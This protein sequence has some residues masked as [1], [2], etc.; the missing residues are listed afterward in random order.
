MTVTTLT[1][2]IAGSTY[3]ILNDGSFKL[4]SKIDETSELDLTIRDE[5]SAWIFSKG[6]QVTLTDTLQGTIFTGFVN[7]SI[8]TKLPGTSSVRFHQLTC[9]DNHFL[10]LKRT[11]NKTY[12]NQ[13]AGVVVA[14]MVND[15]LAA[16]GVTANYAIREDS[17]EE[18]FSQGTLS[19]LVATSNNGGDLELAPAG[20]DVTI[21][22]NTSALFS[23]GTLQGTTASNNALSPTATPTI[24]MQCTQ[25]LAG[26]P[27]S[28]CYARIWSPGSTFPVSSPG[29]FI[30]YDIFI[31]PSSPEC[32]FGVDITF[33]DGT[34]LRDNFVYS[35]A[36]NLSPHPNTDLSSY[37][38]G[39][40]YHREFYLANFVGKDIYYITIAC[41]GDKTGTYTAY[42]KN[43]NYENND[44]SF[45]QAFFSSSL[46]VNPPQVMLTS[47]Y[48]YPSISVV[49]TCDCWSSTPARF[50]PFYSV[51]AVKILQGSFITWDT[52]LP[53]GYSMTVYCSIDGNNSLFPCNNNTALPNV[54]PGI[55][56]SGR[57]VSF[58]VRFYATTSANPEQFPSLTNFECVL[59][60]SY[61][62][63]KID[64]SYTTTGSWSTGATLTNTVA[65]S[66]VLNLIGSVRNWDDAN[67]SGQSTF[68][69]SSPNGF[70]QTGNFLLSTG[71][72]ST[73]ARSEFT[74]AGSYQNFTAEI[75][76][77]IESGFQVGFV[78][79]TTFWG[80]TADTY[81]YMIGVTNTAI[82]FGHGTNNSSGGFT[83]ISNVSISIDT[84][85]FH[86][87][88]IIV[89]G[90]NHQ[91]L[92]DGI[93]YINAT[94]STFPLSGGVG[95]RIYNPTGSPQVGFFDN[96]GIMQS[97]T[98]TWVSPNTSIA[99][100][101]TYGTS[102]IWWDDS[103]AAQGS[104]VVVQVSYNAGSTYATCANGQPLPGLT[105][106]QSLTGVSAQFRVTLAAPA[107]NVM[108]GVQFF[109]VY[110]LGQFSSSG[111][112]ITPV[113]SL[114]SAI[115]C[116]SAT[117]YWNETTPPNTTFALATSLDNITYNGIFGLLGI[118]I[119]GLVTQPLPILDTYDID[120]HAAYTHLQRTGGSAGTWVWDTTNSRVTASGGTNDMQ[121]YAGVWFN[122]D[123]QVKKQ[124]VIDHTQVVGGADLTNYP[125]L[126]SLIDHDLSIPGGYVQNGHGYDIIFV[127]AAE[128]TQLNHEIEFYNPATGEIEMWVQIPTL[129]HSADTVIW[130]Y[131]CNNGIS[132][133][134]EHVTATWDSNYKA[135][136]H[137]DVATGTN[138][139]DSTSNAITATQH[140]SPLQITGQVDGSLE[141]DGVTQYLS[142]AHGSAADIT[143]DKTVEMLINAD[144]FAL[145]AS[146][147]GPRPLLNNIDGTNAYEIALTAGG[148][149]NFAV[150]DSAGQHSIAGQTYSTNVWYYVV[151][152][153]VASTHT[154][155]LYINGVSVNTGSS[156]LSIGTSSLFN[157][158]RRTDALGYFNG[159]IDET[160][161]SNTARSAGWIG[162]ISNNLLSPETFFAVGDITFPLT[163]SA[164]D[165]DLIVDMDQADCAGIVWRQTDASNFY[166]L[167]IFDSASSAGSTNV[168]KL[169]KVV[170]NTKTQIG[171]NTAITFT[172]GTPYRARATMVG[173]SITVY[174]DGTSVLTVTDSSL[175]GP[176]NAG[177]IEVSG[178]AH[179]YN[180]R[181]QPLGQSLSGVNL[182]SKITLTSS[183]PTVTPY[184]TNLTLAV[185]H[186]NITLGSL[187]PTASYLYTYVSKNM[188]DLAKKSNTYWKIDYGL[189]MIFSLYQSIPAPWVVTDKDILVDALQLTNNG[190]LY[191]NRQ[192]ITGV[193]ATGIGNEYKIGDG[194]TR[195]WN[196][197]A[198]LISEPTIYLNGQL[199]TVGVKGIDTGKDFYWTP[200][201]A[202]IDQDTSGILLQETDELFFQNYEY[203]YSTSVVINN[204]GQFPGT[205]SQSQFAAISGGTGIVE[206]V[207]D[208]SSQNL[209]LTAATAMAIDLLQRFGVIGDEIQFKTLR[210]G[211]EIGQYIN[212]FNPETSLYD[213]AMLITEIDM[214]QQTTIDASSGN[215]T[216]LYTYE[217]TAD[218]AV[219]EGSWAK[220]LAST[221]N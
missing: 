69:T 156:A 74:F 159:S 164:K 163:T 107:G 22:E 97:L 191:R 7:T 59:D 93:L 119:A 95:P 186:P 167:D 152:T 202:V 193:I 165:I 77:A 98:G 158:G 221:V 14:G 190:D 138:Q 197:G 63:S 54:P 118:D 219:N 188:D 134:Q 83:L 33:T 53:A 96:F 171:S 162:T 32:K 154:V 176:G 5:N 10:A 99:S 198:I 175:A 200:N 40:W 4:T 46:N 111:T 19:G 124:I 17:T 194:T 16:E 203:Q 61:A 195:S 140:N 28:F 101:V 170:S 105:A 160:R 47:G 143:G 173:T 75:D 62:S 30:A 70:V 122:T 174:F 76:L 12:T 52:T 44:H 168:L 2:N 38:S 210:S 145:D 213:V 204:T 94:D 29:E 135:I 151:G 177:I 214:T 116:G 103:V 50:S 144:S 212:I 139:N 129:S 172:R 104:S 157:I 108:P 216:Q 3:P 185:L 84:N 91:F 9:I 1:L 79:R 78:Y 142:V 31:D 183:D 115:Q 71:S 169:Y 68:G 146:G 90:N 128:T 208:V 126:V 20:S 106:G 13:Y 141:F 66:G 67:A 35:D 37:A 100:A 43:I 207:E 149:F 56:F 81:A 34:S 51:D 110:V 113:L 205:I 184:V 88:Q 182:Y 187:I 179:F 180:L 102:V 201:S 25:S 153:Y 26:N 92:I 211:L 112:R 82:Q 49:N 24:K 215:P 155:T 217:V 117:A 137:M 123:Y 87:L 148:I 65:N 181:I 161:I 131:F 121:L 89:N 8:I 220:L 192:I 72:A 39:Q 120:D 178:T 196:L 209:N 136:W 80:N 45:N 57:V 36:Q 42:F 109:N 189:N 150:S 199:Q 23:A 73:D 127:N 130:M 11:T 27:N 133:T 21:L 6:Q 166:E 60:T 55:L 85:Q 15:V 58:L 147:A 218:S 132:T 206:E 18:D 86:H 48:R 64:T 125:L 114:S 41:E